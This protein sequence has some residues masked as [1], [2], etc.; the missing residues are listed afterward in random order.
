MMQWSLTASA[1][2][3]CAAFAFAPAQPARAETTVTQI[4]RTD[5]RPGGEVDSMA[6][7][8]GPGGRR[9][10]FLTDKPRDMICI[11]DGSTGTA[12][13][14]WGGTGSEPGQFRRPNGLACVGNSLYVVERDNRRVTVLTLPEGEPLLTFGDDILLKPYGIAAFES[15]PGRIEIYITDDHD[16][17]TTDTASGKPAGAGERVKHFRVTSGAGTK[18]AVFVRSFGDT[19]GP[20]VLTK[21]ESIAADPEDQL[22]YIADEEARSVKLY[23]LDGKFTGRAIGEGVILNDPEGITIHPPTNSWP[24]KVIVVSDQDKVQTK[25]RVF[26]L[27]GQLHGTFVADPIVG[28]TD[29]TLF[30]PGTFG[31]F[32]EGAFYAVHDDIAVASFS[33]QAIALALKATAE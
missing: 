32:Q 7:W 6:M 26:S 5:A 30:V 19:E 18:R 21:V 2:F 12:I 16:L 11:Y 29:G 22:L 28:N 25:F 15:A 9:M 20:G 14:D 3:A 17:G 27:D 33:W 31:S 8:E 24:E 1:I 10:L 4:W 13:G 23:T